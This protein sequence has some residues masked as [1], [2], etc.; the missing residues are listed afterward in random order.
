MTFRRLC[1]LGVIVLAS[2]SAPDPTVELL[3]I[4]VLPADEF[5]DG[6]TSGQFIEPANG[7][8]PPFEHRQPVQGFSALLA[9]DDG[10]FLA[11]ADNG[12]GTRESS[13]DF[14]LRVYELRPDFVTREGGS[15]TIA[16]RSLFV[17]RDPDRQIP[18]PIVADLERYPGGVIPVDAAIRDGRLLT[19]ADFDVESFRRVSDGTFWFGDEFGPFLLHTDSTGRLMEA[20]IPL[21][22]VRSP[23]SPDLG[24]DAPNLPRSGG[25]EAMALSADATELFPMLEKPLSGDSG[26][27]NVYRFDLAT[28]RYAARD[29]DGVAYRYP[30]D[31]SGEAVPEL[32][33]WSGDDF[34]VIERDDGEGPAARFKRVFRVSPS[35]IDADG[36]L[37]K[38]E[39]VDLLD[40]PDPRD[41]GGSGTGTF[42]FP[43]WT[44]EAIVVVDESTIGIINDNNYPFSVGRHV[45]TGAPD[46]SEFILLRVR[47]NRVRG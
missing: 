39:I 33:H 16:A 24:D 38:T 11:L 28:G 37:R 20:P 18:F 1:P 19:G 3:G 27:L 31:P 44:I 26:V 8:T 22:G 40:I 23:Q 42:S 43:F 30:L 4:A 21:P 45:D 10:A 6:P 13:P 34:L 12:F 9:G 36:L 41:L 46:D 47:R 7:R 29:A 35:E 32:V 15:G 14:L 25:F 5:V 17:L 2:C